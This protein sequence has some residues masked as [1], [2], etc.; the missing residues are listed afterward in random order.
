MT[1]GMNELYISTSLAGCMHTSGNAVGFAA[2]QERP[3]DECRGAFFFAFLLLLFVSFS[4]LL[5]FSLC[6][7]HGRSSAKATGSQRARMGH[8]GEPEGFADRATAAA[9]AAMAVVVVVVVM[10][11]MV[12]SRPRRDPELCWPRRRVR[13]RVRVI[14]PIPPRASTQP[15][16][17]PAAEPG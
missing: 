8:Q 13:V 16:P 4:F 1:D 14:Q 6:A 17:S 2:S 10:V 5:S 9:M 15:D 3:V 12:V 7:L 11:V